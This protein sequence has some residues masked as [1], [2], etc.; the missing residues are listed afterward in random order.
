MAGRLRDLLRVG[1][2]PPRDLDGEALELA[3][4]EPDLDQE[5]VEPAGVAD[6]QVP[7][8]DDPVEAGEGPDDVLLMLHPDAA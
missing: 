1:L 4:L 5:L 7:L 6:R 8:E 3:E 2:R